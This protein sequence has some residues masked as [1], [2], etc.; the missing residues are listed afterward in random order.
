MGGKQS[1]EVYRLWGSWWGFLKCHKTK[2][3]LKCMLVLFWRPE[4]WENC[5]KKMFPCVKGLSYWW[6]SLLAFSWHKSGL[7]R[8]RE[9]Y[10]RCCI[11]LIHQH[12]FI[13]TAIYTFHYDR[14]MLWL[15]SVLNIYS[16]EA[17]NLVCWEV[18]STS[19]EIYLQLYMKTTGNVL[20]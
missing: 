10:L 2:R 4:L 11:G 12:S 19:C 6:W 14:T 3:H 13:S 5:Q 15:D 20:Y 7:F 16:P 18:S 8:A 9:R 17:S 1:M